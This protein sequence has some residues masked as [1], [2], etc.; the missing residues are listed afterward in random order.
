VAQRYAEWLRAQEAAGVRFTEQQRWWLDEIARHIGINV[1]ISVE[2]L[3]L[4]GFQRRGGQVAA[5]RLFGARLPELI[6]ELNT[7]LS[8]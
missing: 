3:N 7:S 2:D 6:E 5:A 1:S 4:Y 8:E